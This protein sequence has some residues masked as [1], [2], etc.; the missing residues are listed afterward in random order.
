MSKQLRGTFDQLL[1]VT[2]GEI[3]GVRGFK[4]R[5]LVLRRPEF[6]ATM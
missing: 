2:D 1:V 5:L 6:E 4:T 3:E